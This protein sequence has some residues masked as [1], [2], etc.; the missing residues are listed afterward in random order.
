MELLSLEVKVGSQWI[1]KP[2][3]QLQDKTRISV[4]SLT[5]KKNISAVRSIQTSGKD[6]Q[7]YFKGFSVTLQ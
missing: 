5:D 6:V 1:T 7:V 2:L 3:N 4:S